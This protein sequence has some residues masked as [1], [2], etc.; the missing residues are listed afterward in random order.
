MRDATRPSASLIISMPR[1]PPI[2]L[3]RQ[4]FGLARCHFIAYFASIEASLPY[5]Y[6]LPRSSF[7]R[8]RVGDDFEKA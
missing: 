5:E 6:M 2:L 8:C 1:Q 4:S 7:G 3:P